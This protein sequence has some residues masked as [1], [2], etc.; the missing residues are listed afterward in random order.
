MS[1]ACCP[2]SSHATS[3]HLDSVVGEFSGDK[4]RPVG[5]GKGGAI[6]QLR[7][8]G[9]GVVAVLSLAAGGGAPERKNRG[10]TGGRKESG[11][12]GAR[13][14]A[15][16]HETRTLHWGSRGCSIPCQ[17]PRQTGPEV[18][19]DV[20]ETGGGRECVLCVVRFRARLGAWRLAPA[21]FLKR[22]PPRADAH[23]RGRL[24]TSRTSPI[25]PRNHWLFR[26]ALR[27]PMLARPPPRPTLASTTQRNAA[28]LCS[29]AP[30][31]SARAPELLSCRSLARLQPG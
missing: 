20:V 27:G 28:L 16:A 31:V 4:A 5:D 22:L 25:A 8:A 23:D 12:A 17:A 21:L 24:P 29:P 18:G 11:F 13:L 15:H 10:S 1:D 9:V 19:G 7:A 26:G 14:L 6:G 3:A 30:G 2:F